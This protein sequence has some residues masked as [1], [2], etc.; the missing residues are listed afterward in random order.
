MFLTVVL[1]VTALAP[2]AASTWLL[3]P[4]VPAVCYV[5]PSGFEASDD[6]KYNADFL[7]SNSMYNTAS[8]TISSLILLTS[9]GTRVIRLFDSSSRFVHNHVVEAPS[10]WLE[11]H[12]REKNQ[13]GQWNVIRFLLS[14]L[15]LLNVAIVRA[16]RLIYTSFLWE[17]LEQNL[18]CMA[19]S[20][21]LTERADSMA[22]VYPL[23]GYRSSVGWI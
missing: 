10:T 20:S 16:L 19:Q 7:Q 18:P 21:P 1:L 3:Y 6:L 8:M 15:L 14:N 23:M 13:T 4:G 2:T 22:G 9:Y 5:S 11:R 12:L 17:V